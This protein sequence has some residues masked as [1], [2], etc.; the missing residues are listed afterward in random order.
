MSGSGGGNTSITKHSADHGGEPLIRA[1]V[2]HVLFGAK[3]GGGSTSRAAMVG[4]G[5]H[6]LTSPTQIP[7]RPGTVIGHLDSAK[8]NPGA[9]RADLPPDC[10]AD[11]FGARAGGDAVE[12]DWLPRGRHWQGEVDVVVQDVG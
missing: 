12:D 10:D 3:G 8:G 7:D 11:H 5:L 9:L 1:L 6:G 4:S 2:S